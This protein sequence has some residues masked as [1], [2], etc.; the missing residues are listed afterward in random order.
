MASRL[1][2]AQFVFPKSD[3][4][5]DLDFFQASGRS[6]DNISR[7]RMDVARASGT[8]LASSLRQNTFL[9]EKIDFDVKTWF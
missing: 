5:Q 6:R 2:H 4:F 8:D 3:T 7:I 9:I 1:G